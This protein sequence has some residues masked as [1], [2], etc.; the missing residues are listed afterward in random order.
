M[1]N[2]PGSSHQAVASLHN[3]IQYVPTLPDSPTYHH[4][5]F[6]LQLPPSLASVQWWSAQCPWG[7]GCPARQP[8]KWPRTPSCSSSAQV[9]PRT[10]LPTQPSFPE[11][12]WS[13][14]LLLWLS[15][16]GGEPLW[17]IIGTAPTYLLLVRLPGPQSPHL[18]LCHRLGDNS[19]PGP[20][21]SAGRTQLCRGALWH[22]GPTHRSA[23]TEGP[24]TAY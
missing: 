13:E 17:S 11:V 23:G 6:P 24:C 7:V 21:V 20:G 4:P 8:W 18:T 15:E 10:Q 22:H 16:G 14:L 9:P 19:C 5:S 2:I 1:R 12:L 3:K